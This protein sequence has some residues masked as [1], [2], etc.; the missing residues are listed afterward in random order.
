MMRWLAAV[1]V[2]AAAVVPIT[3]ALASTP[4]TFS[5][6]NS[7]APETLTYAA[8]PI[9]KSAVASSYSKLQ[10]TTVD[11]TAKAGVDYKPL[12][13]TITVAN[14]QLI[15]SVQVPLIYRPGYQGGRSFTV[16]VRAV[17][18]ALVTVSDATVTVIETDPQPAPPPA[19]T[20]TGSWV[21][22]PLTVGGYAWLKNQ[23]PCCNGLIVKIVDSGITSDADPAKRQHWWSL[24]YYSDVSGNFPAANPYWQTAWMTG[25]DEGLQGLAPAP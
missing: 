9:V 13:V 15:A 18:N 11:G 3:V 22:A 5:V 10:V 19:P 24:V 7:G 6:Q 23:G 14:K 21:A 2:L 1:A 8:V 25:F 4:P 16:H 17:R 12:N 20:P